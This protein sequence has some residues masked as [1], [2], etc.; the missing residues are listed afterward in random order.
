MQKYETKTMQF[1]PCKKLIH[2]GTSTPRWS[3]PNEGSD[4]QSLLTHI[5]SSSRQMGVGVVI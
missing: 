1:L 4:G 3:P 5:F 2:I